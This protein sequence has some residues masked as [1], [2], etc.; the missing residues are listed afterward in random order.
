[1]IKI[2]TNT[3]A[4]E[5]L[6]ECLTR[7]TTR[8]QKIAALLCFLIKNN[9]DVSNIEIYEESEFEY[10]EGNTDEGGSDH[11]SLNLL[12]DELTLYDFDLCGFSGGF[13]YNDFYVSL[14]YVS[15]EKEEVDGRRIYCITD[16]H[17]RMMH[18]DPAEY[19]TYATMAC[20][21]DTE[22]EKC[23]CFLELVELCKKY[24]K[25]EEELNADKYG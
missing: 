2:S 14:G 16:G 7:N 4:Y 3:E 17:C 24:K 6:I 12:P 19:V 10:Y 9:L 11:G 15:P 8:E 5:L 13:H 1:M 25:M 18:V 22:I 20:I 23:S 21:P